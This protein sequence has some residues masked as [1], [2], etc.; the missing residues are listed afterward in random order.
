MGEVYRARDTRLGRTVAIKVLSATLENDAQFRDRF[1]R[2]ART[3]SR[4]SHP[5]IC[6]LHD[7]GHDQGRL[8]SFSS[9]ST[10]RRSNSDSHAA[11]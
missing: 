2:E 3:I 11:R 1:E 6:V 4:L 8:F 10:G 9:T 7:V 5:N